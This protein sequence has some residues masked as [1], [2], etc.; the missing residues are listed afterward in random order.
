MDASVKGIVAEQLDDGRLHPVAYASRSISNAE[1]N[2]SIT[3]LE[4]LV[5]VWAVQHFRVY[6]YGHNVTVIIWIIQL[7]DLCWRH[8]VPMGNM[9]D[10]G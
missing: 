7:S 8:Q 1:R 2:Y 10:G 3:E 4:T 5:V 6:L 9:L